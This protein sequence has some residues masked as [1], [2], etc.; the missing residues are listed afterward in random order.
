MRWLMTR[1]GYE[2]MAITD[3]RAVL[4]TPGF[5]QYRVS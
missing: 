4:L 3:D 2:G 1:V 5:D